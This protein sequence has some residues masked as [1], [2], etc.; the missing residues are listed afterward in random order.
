MGAPQTVTDAEFNQFVKQNPNVII[1]MWAPTVAARRAS[2]R[3]RWRSTISRLMA[4]KRSWVCT[5]ASVSSRSIGLV[6]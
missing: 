6:M 1:D 4:T 3:R 2:W 5:R